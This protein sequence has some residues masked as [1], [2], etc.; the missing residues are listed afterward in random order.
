VDILSSSQFNLHF[1]DQLFKLTKSIRSNFSKDEPWFM[2]ECHYFTALKGCTIATVFDEPST[3]TKS[4]F[5]AAVMRLGGSF[6]SVDTMTSSMRKG[7]SFED[8]I[9][10]ISQYADVIVIRH[11]N[12]GAAQ[13][14]ARVSDVPVINAGDGAGEHPTQA[15]IDLF[16]IIDEIPN[17]ERLLFLGDIQYARTINSLAL[18]VRRVF[19][20]CQIHEID[21]RNGPSE[22]LE[23]LPNL[24]RAADVVYMTRL[25]SERCGTDGGEECRN[26][27]PLPHMKEKSILLHPLPR[28]RELSIECDAD[29]RAAYWRQVKN[30]LYL[31]MA[32]LKII[33]RP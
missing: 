28:T 32:L 20:D 21:I 4:S 14:A 6:F 26:L 12:I 30:G 27:N 15:L 2:R 33:L 24:L 23:K 7:E 22:T 11:P 8:T 3:R 16:T 31:R 1:L 19:E 13:T 5:E 29:P 9:K 25:Q 17:F 18:L 10:T